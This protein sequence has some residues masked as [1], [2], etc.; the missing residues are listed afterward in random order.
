M[1]HLQEGKSAPEIATLLK[2]STTYVYNIKDIF[3]EKGV[4]GLQLGQ[5][6]RRKGEKRK[7]TPEQEQKIRCIIL[8]ETPEQHHFQ[9][10]LWTR[11]IVNANSFSSLKK[12][13][14]MLDC[15]MGVLA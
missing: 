6:G 1:R 12:G 3:E 7:L 13:V 10:A 14:I 4:E 9:E 15:D 5:R 11:N 2:V 8:E